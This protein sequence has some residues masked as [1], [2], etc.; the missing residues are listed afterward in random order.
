MPLLPRSRHTIIWLGVA[1]ILIAAGFAFSWLTVRDFHALI[2]QSLRERKAAGTLPAEWQ[3]ID[4]E[5]V[6]ISKLGDFQMRIPSGMESRL[7]MSLL[8][9]D[10]WYVWSPVVVV[11][12]LAMAKM[13]GRRVSKTV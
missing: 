8:L 6:D 5:T 2:R 10:F 11:L 12:C 3:N 7:Q 4:P 13:T 9:S 1:V